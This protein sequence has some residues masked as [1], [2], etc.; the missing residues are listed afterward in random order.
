MR[1]GRAD[2]RHFLGVT[3][4]R[5]P[6]AHIQR[7]GCKSRCGRLARVKMAAIR[8]RLPRYA[9][10]YVCGCGMVH[11]EVLEQTNLL[12]SACGSA[13]RRGEMWY[14]VRRAEDLARLSS[15]TGTARLHATGLG[16]KRTGLETVQ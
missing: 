14:D 10:G 3:R 11:E 2:A 16:V 13:S 12:S 6:R 8:D 15:G 7:F 1:S 5:F 9:S 4:P